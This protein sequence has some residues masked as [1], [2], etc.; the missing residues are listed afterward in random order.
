MSSATASGTR[1]GTQP[2][3][4]SIRGLGLLA[5]GLVLLI[6]Y[7]GSDSRKGELSA[8][9]GLRRG[10]GAADSVNGTSV[11]A[12]LFTQAGHRVNSAS[13]LSRRLDMYST[14]VWTPDDFGP[15]STE[16]RQFLDAWL[17]GGSNRTLV[18]I[19]R[20]YDAAG[21][22]WQRM[23]TTVDD[24]RR[25]EYQRRLAHAESEFASRRA[26]FPEH[27]PCEWF[28]M[29]SEHPTRKIPDLDGPWA[30]GIDAAQTDI[31][32]A[33]RLDIPEPDDDSIANSSSSTAMPGFENNYDPVTVLL[34]SENDILA[35]RYQQRYWSSSKV[36]V[37]ANGSFTLNMGLVNKEHRKLADKLVKECGS[38]GRVAFLESGPTGVKV[39]KGNAPKESNYALRIFM[40]WPVS[41]IFIHFAALGIVYCIFAFPIFGRPRTL[42]GQGRSDFGEHVAALGELFQRTKDTFFAES[43]IRQYQAQSKRTSGQAHRGPS[44]APLNATIM[45]TIEIKPVHETPQ[46]K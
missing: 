29:E 41:F 2:A 6:I 4:W 9:Y 36:I 23:L 33:G 20:D 45:D 43:R 10:T 13:E 8:K 15:P 40:I 3:N 7:L 1:S 14:I 21:E 12:E 25:D 46:T 5:F 26:E 38:P 32:L 18:Y 28:T 24:D 42:P 17:A 11:L 35:H 34:Q 39:D 30:T 44:T 37:I 22:Y 16:A 19:G 31:V 27:K